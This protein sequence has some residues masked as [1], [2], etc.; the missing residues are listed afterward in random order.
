MDQII[1]SHIDITFGFVKGIN[2]DRNLIKKD[3]LK[4]TDYLKQLHK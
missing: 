2:I 4:P 1:L 3:I